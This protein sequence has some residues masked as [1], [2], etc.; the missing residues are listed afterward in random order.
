MK[1][2]IGQQ[3]RQVQATG[4]RGGG[5]VGIDRRGLEREISEKIGMDPQILDGFG[6]RRDKKIILLG[7]QAVDPIGL[8]RGTH[9]S[10][11]GHFIFDR[12]H[13]DMSLSMIQANTGACIVTAAPIDW[14]L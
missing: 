5:A 11:L 2:V 4:D 10:E 8:G 7:H 6:K 13:N 1:D 3:Q 14:R 12:D 9:G